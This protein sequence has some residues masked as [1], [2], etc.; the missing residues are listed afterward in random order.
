MSEESGNCPGQALRMSEKR[1]LYIVAEPPE[2]APPIVDALRDR[3]DVR[4]VS[5]AEAAEAE[6][7]GDGVAVRLGTAGGVDPAGLLEWIDEGVCMCS[8]DGERRWDAFGDRSVP[9]VRYARALN[10]VFDFGEL[11]GRKIG[12]RR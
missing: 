5:S 1:T 4:I 9:V 8:L 6:R 12:Q 11:A 7:R 2:A 10:P 3:F